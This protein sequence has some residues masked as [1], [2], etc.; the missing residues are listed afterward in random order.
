MYSGRVARLVAEGAG[1]NVRLL[2]ILAWRD[3]AF[4]QGWLLL[5]LGRHGVL[6]KLVSWTSLVLRPPPTALS[7]LVCR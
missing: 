6:C 4:L 3:V 2:V 5:S 7:G 1:L